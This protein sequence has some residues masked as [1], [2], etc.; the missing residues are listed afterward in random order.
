MLAF[1]G[2]IASAEKDW[3]IGMNDTNWVKSHSRLLKNNPF[4]TTYFY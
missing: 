4:L 3:L 1:A 2:A